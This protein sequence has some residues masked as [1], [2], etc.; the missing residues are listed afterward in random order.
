MVQW[1]TAWYNSREGR[2]GEREEHQFGF[3]LSEKLP[4]QNKT[5]FP[6]SFSLNSNKTENGKG[7]DVRDS[8]WTGK[9]LIVEV[10]ENG[11]RRVS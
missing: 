2:G 8:R 9:G 11:K 4:V 6:F 7:R 5:R 1:V 10:A 3:N